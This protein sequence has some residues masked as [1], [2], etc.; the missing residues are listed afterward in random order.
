MSITFRLLCG[1][2]ISLSAAAAAGAQTTIDLAAGEANPIW[3]GTGAGAH[4]GAVFDHGAV[5]AS[6]SRRDLLIGAP[7]G[8]GVRGAV[9][10]LP[11]GPT[12]SGDL[13]LSGASTIIE[14][15]DAGD[16]FGTAIA[17][18]N[19]LTAEDTTPKTLV[20]AAP[21]A[22]GNRGVVY[23]F[24]TGFTGENTYSATSATARILGR[25]GERLGASLATADMN[26][27]GYREI[28]IGAPGSN[29]IHMILGGP[30][31][32]GTIDLTTSAPAW[33]FS[34]PGLGVTVAAG[35]VTG[36]GIYDMVV[37]HPMA[38]AVHVLK[39]RNG[40]MPP[41]TFD[42]TF[43]KI[44]G[45][46]GIGT[47]IR[48]ADVDSDDIADLIIGAPDAGGPSNARPRAGEVYLMW[49]GPTLS[50]RTLALADV[51]FLG[52]VPNARMGALLATG[53]IN[54]DS[55]T[56]LVLGSPGARNGVGVLDIYYGRK[57]SSIGVSRVDGRRVVDFAV[58][59]ADRTIFGDI[60]G[61]TIT[62]AQV[63]E[64]TGEG[65]QDVI[66]G[67]SGNRGGVGAV[68]FTISPRLTLGTSTVS[69]AGYQGIVSSSPVLTSNISRIPITWRTSS[70]RSWLSAT[71]EDST[72]AGDP[73]SLVIKANG[74]G[75]PPGMHTGTITVTSTS[76]HLTMF[77]RISVTFQVRETQPTPAMPPASGV[78][79]GPKWKLFWRHA[80]D[81][82]LAVWEMDG[83][84]LTGTSSISINQM[85]SSAWK[86]AG[87]GD[88]NG[89]GHRDLV[90]Q[91]D[92]GWLAA[93]FLQGTRVV[94]AGYLSI[95]RMSDS[96]WKIRGVGDTDGDR[97]ADLLWQNDADGSLAVWMMNGA[98]VGKTLMLS[99]PRQSVQAWQIR[100]V[101][102]TNGDGMADLLWHRS[103]T[104]ELG[105][106][107]LQG[108]RVTGTIPLSIAAMTDTNWRIAGAEDVNGDRKVDILW[109]HANGSLA[110]WYLNGANVIGTRWLNPSNTTSTDWK[111][112][113]P[114]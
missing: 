73:G 103:D 29:S 85:T 4:A 101:G 68:Y 67:M 70:N 12:W 102:D 89:D 99:V 48:L 25:A 30:T 19:V 9:Y 81:H 77:R 58:E 110:T 53:D 50:G 21:A 18:G 84:S 13:S 31:L 108:A 107:Y 42:M 66:V 22:L 91:H 90:W 82:W 62:A 3:R 65:A 112:A 114:K 34:Y 72:S 88:L 83:V 76:V 32:S 97:R 86:I 28:I 78:A 63:Y 96:R 10:V 74:Q 109:Q 59:V 27:D 56:D 49:G 64:V 113:G 39:G 104:G 93:W 47:A 51:T 52:A 71:S 26:N 37:G 14:G 33:T 111:V 94:M 100:A 36:D 44:G 79:H 46:D 87:I 75:L 105:V 24:K 54:R 40:T 43:G 15:A 98:Q 16:L 38:N 7:G 80:V 2:A 106:W 55:P 8:P 60:G 57:R 1:L 95:N 45:A 41:Q 69:L 61:G 23:V 20:V 35:D 5:R 92:D 11:G 6:D 17:V